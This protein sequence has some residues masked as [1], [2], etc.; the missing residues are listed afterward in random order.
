MGQQSK[1]N[2]KEDPRGTRAF[3]EVYN[4]KLQEISLPNSPHKLVI[5][6]HSKN[7]IMVDAYLACA[8]MGLRWRQ[9][10]PKL[11]LSVDVFPGGTSVWVKRE[12]FSRWLDSI[13][14]GQV[15]EENRATV[16]LF[17]DW[18]GIA[19]DKF[20][21]DKTPAPMEGTLDFTPAPRE[22]TRLEI[23]QLALQAEEERLQLEEQQATTTDVGTVA[24][25]LINL[26][27]ELKGGGDVT[28]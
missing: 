15:K 9:Q 6:E 17:R 13:K 3:G 28:G 23:L 10:A 20:L 26:A 24:E 7:G 18:H 4:M 14:V 5:A 21:A 25:Q 12:E 1:I 2:K 27:K 22:L 19:I 16:E 11:N 8:A